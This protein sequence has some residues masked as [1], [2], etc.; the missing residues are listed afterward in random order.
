MS[1]VLKAWGDE[2]KS[3]YKFD[4][5]AYIFG[6]VITNGFTAEANAR[7]RL[8]GLLLPGQKKT[9][10]R[11]ESDKRR[12]QIIEALGECNLDGIVVTRIGAATERDERRRRKCF[13]YF[14][15]QLI[16]FDVWD[17]ALES[18]GTTGNKLDMEMVRALGASKIVPTDFRVTHVG[19]GSDPLLWAADAVCGAVVSYRIGQPKWLLRMERLAQFEMVSRPG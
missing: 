15:R 8:R 7:E 19:G 4:P 6:A 17:L 14:A 10:W 11:D 16:Q 12:D 1:A 18:R 13:E 2:S 3:S 5:G 9:H